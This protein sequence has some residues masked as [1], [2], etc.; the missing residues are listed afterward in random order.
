MSQRVST[1][2]LSNN[3]SSA[4]KQK[5]GVEERSRRCLATMLLG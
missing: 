5:S 2:F 4:D 3:I 1:L